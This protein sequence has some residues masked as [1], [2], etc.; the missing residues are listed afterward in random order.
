[1][2][3]SLAT[4]DGYSR[5]AIDSTICLVS[6]ERT[7]LDQDGKLVREAAHVDASEHTARLTMISDGKADEPTKVRKDIHAKLV[8]RMRVNESMNNALGNMHG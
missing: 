5:S 3:E 2:V 6:V 8:L 7:G 4:T 1:M